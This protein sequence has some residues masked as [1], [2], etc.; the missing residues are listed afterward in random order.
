MGKACHVGGRIGRCLSGRTDDNGCHEWEGCPIQR[1]ALHPRLNRPEVPSHLPSSRQG[2][3]PAY[4]E[5]LDSRQDNQCQFRP[6]QPRR[7]AKTSHQDGPKHA[8]VAD[9]MAEECRTR[10]STDAGPLPNLAV[11]ERPRPPRFRLSSS[12]PPRPGHLRSLRDRHAPTLDRPWTRRPLA[13]GS[14]LRGGRDGAV[15]RDFPDLA[16]HDRPGQRLSAQSRAG[17]LV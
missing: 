11:S 2:G 6:A 15:K 4:Q 10:Q 17:P 7:T 14:R 9:H 5:L 3:S 12:R 13:G 1:A 8:T 16:I